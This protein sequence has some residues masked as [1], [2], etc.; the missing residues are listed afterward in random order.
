MTTALLSA[1][2]DPSAGLKTCARLIVA[3][4]GSGLVRPAQRDELALAEAG[5][6]RD[7]VGRRLLAVGGRGGKEL[8][9]AGS[10]ARNEAS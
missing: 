10:N 3:G 9:S 8:N 5:V 6:G 4:A 2:A 1:R 7:P